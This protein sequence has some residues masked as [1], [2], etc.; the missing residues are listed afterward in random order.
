MKY[1]R[2]LCHVGT[3]ALHGLPYVQHDQDPRGMF[4]TALAQWL[5]LK[6]KEMCSNVVRSVG[7]AAT[8]FRGG[9]FWSRTGFEKR[10]K[11]N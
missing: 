2:C 4:G 9:L 1:L 7:C 5:T 8:V 10:E 6:L 11:I 3:S